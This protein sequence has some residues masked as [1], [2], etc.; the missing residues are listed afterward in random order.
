MA[1]IGFLLIIATPHPIAHFKVAPYP[2]QVLIVEYTFHLS[3]T[4]AVSVLAYYQHRFL[5]LAI[6]GRM[7]MMMKFK[8]A[9]MEENLTTETE[10][11]SR[12]SKGKSGTGKSTTSDSA[13]DSES[14]SV[15]VDDTH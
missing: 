6:R 3:I 14:V 5:T 4:A 15:S 13:V 1:C 7:G 12:T 9:K 2:N 11:H 10:L 8:N